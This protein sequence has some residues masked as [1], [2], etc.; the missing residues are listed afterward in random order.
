MTPTLAARIAVSEHRPLN[1]KSPVRES[2]ESDVFVRF[3]HIFAT[4]RDW[5]R[6]GQLILQNGRYGGRQIVA[7]SANVVF[8][9]D[10]N[11]VIIGTALLA[12]SKNVLQDARLWARPQSIDMVFHDCSVVLGMTLKQRLFL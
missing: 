4:A 10:G 8:D 11:E 6:V 9:H 2:N 3:S 1:I 5:V 12:G 7:E